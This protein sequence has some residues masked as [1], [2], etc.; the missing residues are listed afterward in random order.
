MTCLVFV[1]SFTLSC[2]EVV[3]VLLNR[4]VLRLMDAVVDILNVYQFKYSCREIKW[5]K[6]SLT[7]T[8]LCGDQNKSCVTNAYKQI[9]KQIFSTETWYVLGMYAQLPGNSQ[10][11]TLKRSRLRPPTLLITVDEIQMDT[12]PHSFLI[13]DTV[14]TKQTY[15]LFDVCL[16]TVKKLN[17]FICHQLYVTTT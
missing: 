14:M 13:S 9:N 5:R 16:V 10:S 7:H 15:K 4:R 2:R 6:N 3:N 1:S 11:L 12:I 17:D 8:T